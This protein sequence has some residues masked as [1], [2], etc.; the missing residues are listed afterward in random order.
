MQKHGNITRIGKKQQFMI[1]LTFSIFWE[2]V[3]WS[4]TFII[5]LHIIYKMYILYHKS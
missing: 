4:A 5:S 3:N 1:V 2:Q